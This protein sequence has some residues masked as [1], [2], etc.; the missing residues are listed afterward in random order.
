MHHDL[1]RL[2]DIVAQPFVPSAT[3]AHLHRLV[4]VVEA[5]LHILCSLAF[6]KKEEA[7]RMI[8]NPLA[9]G[10]KGVLDYPLCLKA[11]AP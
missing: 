9:N 2:Q 1:Q 3:M 8:D 6:S 5:G 4:V 7:G 10:H 11:S